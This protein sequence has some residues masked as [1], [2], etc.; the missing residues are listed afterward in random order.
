LYKKHDNVVELLRRHDADVDAPLQVASMDGRG[1]VVRWLLDHGADPDSR[2]DDRQS[3]IHLATVNGHPEVVRTLLGHSARINAVDGAAD[4]LLRLATFYTYPKEYRK[5]TGID[6]L[7]H[8]LMAQL[9]ACDS[10]SDILAVLRTQAQVKREQSTSR[11]D[12]LTSWNSTINVLHAFSTALVSEAGVEQ[13]FSPANVIFA[14]AGVLL[15][16]D[17]S[18]DT[19]VN[20]LDL[21]KNI[22]RRFDGSTEVMTEAMKDVIVKDM[23]E[24]LGIFGAANK[25]PDPVTMAMSIL[26]IMH[27]MLAT[28]ILV[29]Q[30]RS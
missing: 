26:P 8:S 9:Q 5:K 4:N 28:L 7:T 16:S 17:V 2:Q 27:M 6:L 1:V 18:L 11:D 20:T 19:V 10:P 3:P 15:A 13:V 14:A 24:V 23:I 25:K 12:R 21:T 30:L 29:G 22:F